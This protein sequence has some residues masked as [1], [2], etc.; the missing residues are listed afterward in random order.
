MKNIRYILL[1]LVLVLSCV[2]ALAACNK[3]TDT[4]EK[5]DGTSAPSVEGTAAETE[6]A[7]AGTEAESQAPSVEE[8]VADTEP[9]EPG[10]ENTD[11]T[12]DN[13]D[14]DPEYYVVINSAE[15]LMNFNKKVNEMDE[16]GF[17]VNDFY[18]MTVVFTA[19]IDMTGYDWIPLNG[20]AIAYVTFDGKGHTVSNLEI[21]HDPAQ[22][23]S[24]DQIGAG[25]VGVATDD[26]FFKD[27]TFD[28]CHIT[29]Y[30]RAVGNL[31]GCVTNGFMTFENVNVTNFTVDGWMDYANQD[32]ENGGHPISFRAAGFIGHIMAAG[33]SA[34]FINC[35]VDK[36]KLSGFH[37]LAGFIGYA[38]AA[39]DEYCF[40]NCSV[41][42]AEFTFSYCMSASY[43]IDQPKKYVSVFYNAADW[44]DNVQYVVDNGNTF[45][46]VSYFDWTD[47][48]AEYTAG[49]FLS[50]T[51]EEA[52]APA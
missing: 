21:L 31:I 48:N 28:N 39:V 45:S 29:A 47:D 41:S 2:F 4:N 24:T 20:Q 22:G 12:P 40:E 5:N 15:D 26:L 33:S 8:T 25:F 38:S 14:Y 50:W 23:T 36:I 6:T 51:R 49:E 37:N 1:C 19:D 18:E 3:D 27:I 42:N 52:N 17:L 34:D 9:S 46:S 30:E 10:E 13:S 11:G 7:D 44:A 35:N 16:D 43:T 32:R